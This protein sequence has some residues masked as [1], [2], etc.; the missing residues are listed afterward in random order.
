LNN[1]KNNHPNS[2][3]FSTASYSH[4]L[5][6]GQAFVR[7]SGVV[8]NE[9]RSSQRTCLPT[10]VQA[11]RSTGRIWSIAKLPRK[12]PINWSSRSQ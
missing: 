9:L 8:E 11:C 4:G 3:V 5:P 7:L 2:H 6:H 1:N 10:R 12:L